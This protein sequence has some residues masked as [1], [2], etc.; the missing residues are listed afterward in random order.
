MSLGAS[1]QQCRDE[2]LA[3]DGP[4]NITALFAGFA[5]AL[6]SGWELMISDKSHRLVELEYY[7]HSENHPDPFV[8][9]A[10][11]QARQGEWY[12]HREKAATKTFT[13]KGLDLTFGQAKPLV[14]AGILI[15]AI[16]TVD[17]PTKAA[18]LV[19]GPSKVVDHILEVHGVES[20]MK[21]KT[22][23]VEFPDSLVLRPASVI[24][25]SMFMSQRFGLKAKS[26]E[27]DPDGYFHS[28]TYRFR[29]E[30]G[31]AKSSQGKREMMAGKRYSGVTTSPMLP[32][33]ASRATTSPPFITIQRS[34]TETK[35]MDA[36]IDS[37]L[38]ETMMP[39]S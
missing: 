15:R 4:P 9:K 17:R 1:L 34:H 12:F 28:A 8:H 31:L 37:I 7:V 26:E 22:I 16:S 13:L 33:I 27:D 19:Q 18:E 38:A 32:A 24:P 2:A 5:Y 30:P 6:M 20:V 3:K 36:F 35:E 29:I 25:R 14:Y 39:V 21:L 10:P 11:A 23:L